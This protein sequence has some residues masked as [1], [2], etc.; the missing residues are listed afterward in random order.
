MMASAWSRASLSCCSPLSA[1]AS[2]C[3]MR[4]SRSFIGPRII[5]QTNFIVNQVS[6]MNTII[7]TT[8]VRLMF[9][10]LSP[11]GGSARRS[12][13]RVQRAQERIREREEQR[14]ADADHRHRVQ[15]SRDHE[16]LNAQHRQQ[17]R[18]ARRALDE[19]PAQ[20]TEADGGAGRPQSED[21]A[22]RQHGHGLDV[23][24]FHSALLKNRRGYTEPSGVRCPSMMLAGQRQVDNRQ[25]HEYEGLQHDDQ[26]VKDRPDESEHDLYDDPRPSA[27]AG[28]APKPL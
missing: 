28:Q 5:G 12:V 9:T 1:A 10:A 17:L 8:R 20:D 7:C 16:H 25:Y 6:S 3:A 18:L 19:T 22:D 27:D 24:N 21:D 26:H 2:P 15:Q 13:S 11:A 4:V 14:E 23:C